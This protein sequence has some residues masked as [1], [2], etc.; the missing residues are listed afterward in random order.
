MD[1]SCLAHGSVDKSDSFEM[2]FS[3]LTVK[4]GGNGELALSFDGKISIHR[5]LLD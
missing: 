5:E 1:A 4:E 2:P 3:S